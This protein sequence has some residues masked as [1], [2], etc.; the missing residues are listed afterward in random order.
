MGGENMSGLSIEGE[1]R[2]L[3]MVGRQRRDLASSE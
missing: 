2:A 1:R 3:Y